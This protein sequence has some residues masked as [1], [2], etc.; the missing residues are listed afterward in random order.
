MKLYPQPVRQQSGGGVEYLPVPAAKRRLGTQPRRGVMTWKE[1]LAAARV[2]WSLLTF[3]QKF[4]Q[5]VI[6]LLTLLI[7]LGRRAR[8]VESDAQGR[9]ER[10]LLQFRSYRL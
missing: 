5:A 10:H 6:T 8:G 9:E 7:R 2:R 3:Y 4:E 1:E